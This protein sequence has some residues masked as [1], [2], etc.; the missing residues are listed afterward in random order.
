MTDKEL[1]LA[2]YNNTQEIKHDVQFVMNGMESLKDEIQVLK[3]DVQG[4][5][6]EMQVL[7]EDVQGLKEDVRILKEDVQD[8]KER[9]QVLEQRVT[10]I[11]LTLENETNRHI[12]LLAENHITLVDKLNGALRVQDKS[13]LYEIKVDGLQKRVNCLEQEMNELKSKIA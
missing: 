10:N 8:L 4:L 5:K 12:Q 13:M 3:E 2:M 6:D 11:E 7:K 1:L 9:V